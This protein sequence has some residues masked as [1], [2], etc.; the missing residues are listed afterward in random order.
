MNRP[1]IRICRALYPLACL[2]GAG[3]WLRNLLFDRGWLPSRSFPL[4][5]ISVGNLTV[6]GTGKTPHTEYLIRLLLPRWRTAVLSRGYRRRTSGFVLGTSR[7]ISFWRDCSISLE[8]S[9]RVDMD[10]ERFSQD[11]SILPSSLLLSNACRL[12]SRLITI[13]GRLSTIS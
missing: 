3:V 6:G 1:S 5:V 12:P 13:R 4:P 2:Y 8:I 11:L 9:S 10:T 7:T